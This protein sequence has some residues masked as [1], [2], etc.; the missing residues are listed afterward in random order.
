MSSDGSSPISREPVT[1]PI[2]ARTRI[3]VLID[4]ID[5]VSGGYEPQLR[6]AFDTSC[7]ERD[8]DLV[9]VV[10]R[11]FDHPESSAAAQN[12]L[13]ELIDRTTADGVIFLASGLAAFTG[14][15]RIAAVHERLSPRAACSIG[16]A[17]PGV[18][19]VLVDNAWTRSSST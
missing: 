19:S 9:I 6:A 5:H 13:Y 16:L 15:Q 7:R 2:R 4:N 18:T 10:G 17:V 1:R 3:A 8:I 14:P 12:Q 11:A